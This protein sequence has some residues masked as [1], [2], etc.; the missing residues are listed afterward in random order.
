MCIAREPAEEGCSTHPL[1]SSEGATTCSRDDVEPS[2]T[3]RNTSSFCFRTLFTHPCGFTCEKDTHKFHSHTSTDTSSAGVL[4]AMASF[5]EILKLRVLTLAGAAARRANGD[6]F[7]TALHT[8]ML[9]PFSSSVILR[10]C[11]S[12]VLRMRKWACNLHV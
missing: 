11:T 8:S 7:L 10:K 5:T 6:L 12:K 2:L 1:S 9:S 3:S 4:A